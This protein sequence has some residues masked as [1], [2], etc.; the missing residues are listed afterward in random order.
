MCLHLTPV[1]YCITTILTEVYRLCLIEPV[2]LR[3]IGKPTSRLEIS[4]PSSLYLRVVTGAHLGS[5][6]TGA[7]SE[8]T[9]CNLKKNKHKTH[10]SLLRKRFKASLK[11]L[12]LLI[13]NKIRKR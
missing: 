5:A 3:D 2:S 6:L 12:I 13:G 1:L 9:N 4:S 10:Y 7:D 8:L 11:N